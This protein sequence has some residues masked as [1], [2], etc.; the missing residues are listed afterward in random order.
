[1]SRI[2]A[3]FFDVDNTLYD[4]AM[5]V[6]S[7]RR[8]VVLAMIEAGLPVEEKVALE[9][10]KKIVKKYGSNYRFHYDRLMES[11]GL[12]ISP[13]IVS[14]GLVA[15]ANAKSAYITP[16]AETVPTLIDLTRMGLKLGI[17]SEGVPVKQWEK[18]IRLGVQHF[19]DVVVISEDAAGKTPQLFHEACAKAGLK[20]SECM[21]VGD[22]IDKDIAGARKAGLM[23]VLVMTPRYSRIKPKD[24]SETPDY[25]IRALGDLIKLIEDVNPKK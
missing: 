13:R 8:N 18:L 3:V 23:T 14:A 16:Y 6:E 21:M 17:V 7:A 20:P 4:T 25:V 9:R 24:D 12:E 22:R 19:F 5:Q 11:L 1:M 15:Y 10:L 2:K